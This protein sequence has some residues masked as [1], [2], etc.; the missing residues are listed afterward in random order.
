MYTRI[1]NINTTLPTLEGSPKQIK[2]GT[3]LRKRF[4]YRCA[5]CFDI[6]WEGIQIF[7]GQGLNTKAQELQKE[8]DKKQAAMNRVLSIDN[9]S[10]YIDNR[11]KRVE[12]ILR[13]YMS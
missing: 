5:C 10:F 2:W 11:D 4:I 9:A 8:L 7:L 13:L 12:E 6:D 1:L 3:S